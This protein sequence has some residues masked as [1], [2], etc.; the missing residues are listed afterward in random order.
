MQ[1]T[2]NQVGPSGWSPTMADGAQFKKRA[3]GNDEPEGLAPS[4]W[5]DG[6]SLACSKSTVTGN[7]VKDCTDGGA[8]LPFLLCLFSAISR[9]IDN[10][11]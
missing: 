2:N 4:Q 5:A 10:R 11:D 9:S 7:T 3:L 8:F 1:I 6:I